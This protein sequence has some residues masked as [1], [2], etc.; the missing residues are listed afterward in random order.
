M[1]ILNVCETPILATEVNSILKDNPRNA[2]AFTERD[3]LDNPD[4][5]NP[6]DLRRYVSVRRSV[7]YL[8]HSLHIGSL[9]PSVVPRVLSVLASHGLSKDM[10]A[11]LVDSVVLS[12]SPES[13]RI[14]VPLILGDRVPHPDQ[15]EKIRAA[16]CVLANPP[17]DESELTSILDACKPDSTHAEPPTKRRSSTRK[18]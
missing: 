15:V 5:T 13:S 11:R 7:N 18:R 1:K 9:N 4:I 14:Y 8:E 12:G 6:D 3:P 16:V 2:L 10:I 17:S